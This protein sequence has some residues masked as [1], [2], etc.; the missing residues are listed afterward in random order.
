ML[1]KAAVFTAPGQPLEMRE[2]P[3]PEPAPGAVLIK[4]TICNICGSDL[5]AW[6][7]E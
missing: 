5:H 6:R 2:F 3:V 1:A 4:V 7:G